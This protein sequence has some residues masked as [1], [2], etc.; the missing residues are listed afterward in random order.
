MLTARIS[1]AARCGSSA[2]YLAPA[3]RFVTSHGHA[4]DLLAM[5]ATDD[6]VIR[7][8]RIG[9]AQEVRFLTTPITFLAHPFAHF[10]SY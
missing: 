1:I 8:E 2:A 3:S 5:W 7:G 6:I 4:I 9:R 10:E